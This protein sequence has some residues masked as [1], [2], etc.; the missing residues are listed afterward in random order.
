[1]RNL[2]RLPVAAIRQRVELFGKHFCSGSG[3][4][5]RTAV[6]VREIYICMKLNWARND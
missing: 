5:S 3:F 1:M 2:G 6:I 4:P